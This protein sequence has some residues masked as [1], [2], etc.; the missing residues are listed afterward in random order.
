[1]AYIDPGELFEDIKPQFATELTRAR[2][3]VSAEFVIKLREKFKNQVL[4]RME[5][6][7]LVSVSSLWVGIVISSDS[8]ILSL[9]MRL[10]RMKIVLFALIP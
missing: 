3:L 10:L 6:E 7:K 4:D 5:A 9:Q 8:F 1:M 2:R